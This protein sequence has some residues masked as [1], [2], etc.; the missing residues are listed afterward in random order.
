MYPPEVTYHGSNRPWSN[1]LQF[2]GENVQ[3]KIKT[4]SK[5]IK[6]NNYLIGYVTKIL[7]KK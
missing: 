2:K 1:Q 4:A 5:S 7:V 3:L 6:I